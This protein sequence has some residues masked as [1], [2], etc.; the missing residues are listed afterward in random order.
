MNADHKKRKSTTYLLP[1]NE[2]T[3]KCLNAMTYIVYK[4]K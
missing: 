3:N 2:A 4:S 1:A